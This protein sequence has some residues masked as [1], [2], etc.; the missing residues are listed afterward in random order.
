MKEAVVST[1]STGAKSFSR[2]PQMADQWYPSD[3]DDGFLSSSSEE[4]E[5]V[6]DN[7]AP[8]VG[9][10]LLNSDSDE[11][12]EKQ[13]TIRTNKVKRWE[14]LRRITKNLQNRRNINDWS[15]IFEE[16]TE[17]TKCLDK[18]K[19]VIN[20]HGF[21]KFLIASLLQLEDFITETGGKKELLKNM[22]KKNAQSFQ[23]VRQ[24]FKKYMEV[25]EDLKAKLVEWRE[26]DQSYD[27]EDYED[28][29]EEEA[30]GSGGLFNDDLEGETPEKI[31]F[32]E[33]DQEVWNQEKVDKK[34][35]E[36][37]TK[38]GTKAYNKKQHLLEFSF[39]REKAE[40][41]HNK[42]IIDFHIL[43]VLFDTIPSAST[44]S[45]RLWVKIYNMLVDLLDCFALPSSVEDD[46]PL[47]KLCETKEQLQAYLGA[48]VVVDQLTTAPPGVVTGHLLYSL[49]RLGDEYTKVLQATEAPSEQYLIW[50]SH[51]NYLLRLFTYAKQYYMSKG[52][53]AKATVLA[54]KILKFVAYRHETEKRGQPEPTEP[55]A[56]EMSSELLDEDPTAMESLE[57]EPV[58]RPPAHVKDD[59]GVQELVPQLCSFIC[60]Y[61]PDDRHK[62]CAILELI[63]HYAIHDRFFEARDLLLM[64]HLQEKIHKAKPALQVLFNRVM[65]QLGLA[66]FREGRIKDAHN[67]L[68]EICNSGKVKELLA[69]G[70]NTKYPAE[71]SK[72]Q[73][74]SEHRR[75]I[76]YH[77][78]INL[79]LIECVYLTCAMLLEVPNMAQSAHRDNKKKI[80]SKMFHKVM[81]FYDRQIFTGPPEN[82]RETILVAAKALERGDWK[83]CKSLIVSLPILQLIPKNE[84]ILEA[85]GREIQEQSLRTYL[86]TY[87]QYYDS[88]STEQLISMFELDANVVH[89]IISKM[90]ISEELSASWDQPTGALI[91][92]CRD[93]STLQSLALAYTDKINI[94]LESTE[95]PEQKVYERRWN[96]QRVGG[97]GQQSLGLVQ[98]SPAYPPLASQM[99]KK[100][101][102]GPSQGRRFPTTSMATTDLSGFST[103]DRKGK[104][105]MA[106]RG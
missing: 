50:L 84:K 63:Y 86:F 106:P 89:A 65:V 38:R 22:K 12:E 98:A 58:L 18:A 105:L 7:E 14:E 66:A 17:L 8:A 55:P 57:V 47:L 5:V 103:R 4:E 46:E 54:Q 77:M 10:W 90:I 15:G 80:I 81:D 94:L 104:K 71:K 16:W 60:Q 48:D 21:P 61:D 92:H 56:M 31:N 78:H 67:C 76:P 49:E 75:Q 69:Q 36:L 20:Q 82:T 29:E 79:E 72:E 40:G 102:G 85:L 19:A 1:Q 53:L 30:T 34:V 101:V 2:S 43:N 42:L 68:Q 41:R 96:D 52:D 51:E 32:D 88:L 26:S 27:A 62:R 28:S 99:G 74:K 100:L 70:I 25:T 23:T 37:L 6:E 93:P 73:E 24:R 33:E 83:R 11:D 95:P 97:G 3:D 64:T 91:V 9:S 39:L 45:L 35:K 13:R 87:G 44:I 59:W